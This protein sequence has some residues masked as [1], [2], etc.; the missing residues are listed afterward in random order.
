VNESSLREIVNDQ[1]AFFQSGETQSL[2]W[3]RQALKRLEEVLVRYQQKILRAL[4]KD[5]GKP[6]MEAFLTEYHFLLQE[7]RFVRR[8]MKSWLKP[9]KVVSPIYFQ[10]SQSWIERHPFGLVLVVAP[11]NY[12]LQLS[13]SPIVAAIAGGNCV[14]LKPS[15]M[16]PAIEEVLS[17]ILEEV[18]QGRGVRVVRGGVELSKR[19]LEQKFDFIFFTGS[20]QVGREVAVA[21]A[22]SLTPCLLELGGKCPC[23]VD[24]RVDLYKAARRLI[25]GKF[26]NAGQTCFAPDFV[27]V[28]QR[29]AEG[30][31]KVL[32]EVLVSIPWDAEM[33]SIISEQHF[34]RLV[35]LC[36]GEVR[37]F[38]KDEA[39]RNYL[40]PRLILNVTEDHPVM[41]QEVF[42]PILPVIIYS[43]KETLFEILERIESPLAMYCFSKDREFTQ[44]LS[45]RF[46]SGSFCINDTMKQLSQLKLPLGGVGASGYGRYRGRF[47]VDA[48]TYEKSMMRRSFFG[49]DLFELIPPYQRVFGW[50]KKFLR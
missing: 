14:I 2:I 33:A 41:Q 28:D 6:E 3:R 43:Q 27:L 11:W 20:T 42:G 29:I 18:F 24:E 34:E 50:I 5:L 32:S 36:Q 38:G 39:D 48:M 23:I 16:A 47:G 10:P 7:I 49:K 25:A 26:L 17:Q 19:L 1:R 44:L 13:L 21:A 8:G 40:A 12:P 46:P 35:N 31:I 9:K 15:E 4:A 37:T 30:F 22:H 45:S